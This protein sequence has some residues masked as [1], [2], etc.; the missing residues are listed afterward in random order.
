MAEKGRSRQRS[1]KHKESHGQRRGS[2]RMRPPE[3]LL[4]MMNKGWGHKAR[5]R[6]NNA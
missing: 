3:L 5:S 1:R 6:R 2:R 4:I